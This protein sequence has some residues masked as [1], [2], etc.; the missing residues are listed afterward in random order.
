[1]FPELLLLCW[2]GLIVAAAAAAIAFLQCTFKILDA[3]TQA[4]AEIGQFAG[5]KEQ[6]RYSKQ[7]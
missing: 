1:M 4:L 3:F 2:S 7:D 5:A 6:Q